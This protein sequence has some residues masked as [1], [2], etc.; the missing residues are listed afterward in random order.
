MKQYFI[1]IKRFLEKPYSSI[2]GYP[3]SSTHQLKS[4]IS[5]L[6]KLGIKRVS[7]QGQMKLGSLNVLGKGYVGI[8]VLAKKN[9]QTVAVKIR[10]L[11]SPRKQMNDEAKLLKKV[12]EVGVGPKFIGSSKNFLIMEYLDGKKIGE[13]IKN[14][15]GKGSA[16]KFKKIAKTVLED[17]YKLDQV[18]IDHGELSS[19]TKHV[20]IGRSKITL[21]DFES[22]SINRKVS[23]VTSATQGIFIGSGI[24]INAKRIIKLPP[25]NK[26]INVLR[27]YKKQRDRERFDNI[28]NVLNLN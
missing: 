17:C 20:I 11:D 27:N 28:L 15:K 5:E 16:K 26:I 9:T 21:I 22:S 24:S 14:V 2:L 8:V 13:W 7:F 19:V 25:K 6:E 18:G 23:N 1:P 10:R 3:R 12:N 4:R